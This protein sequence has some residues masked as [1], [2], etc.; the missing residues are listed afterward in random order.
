MKMNEEVSRAM[1][2]IMAQSQEVR[3][4]LLAELL[5]QDTDIVFAP[6]YRKE[7]CLRYYY[8]DSD[9]LDD[10]WF[11]LDLDIEE[12]ECKEV[13]D[14]MKNGPVETLWTILEL[15][16][17]DGYKFGDVDSYLMDVGE[18]E[19]FWGY[20]REGIIEK[21]MRH[22]LY[23]SIRRNKALEKLGL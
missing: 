5:K 13:I 17:H 1:K 23:I 22:P 16:K 12:E 18:R 10:E 7:E 2:I 9:Q 8:Y 15:D 11:G 4:Y 14:F 19:S 20:T 21:I 6:L 3:A